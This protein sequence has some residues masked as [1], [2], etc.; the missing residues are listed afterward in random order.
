MRILLFIFCFLIPVSLFS[1]T[2]VTKG[3]T[4]IR[5]SPD[6]NSQILLTTNK[7]VT[8]NTITNVNG[9]YQINYTMFKKGWI[10]ENSLR[11]ASIK[12]CLNFNKY[13]FLLYIIVVICIVVAII[14]LFNALT[15]KCPDCKKLFAIHKTNRIP[16]GQEKITFENTKQIDQLY[17]R[18]GNRAGQAERNEQ[19]RFI[20]R[21]YND[22][23]KCKY[24][25]HQHT[26]LVSTKV[27]G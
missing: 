14:I 26:L 19:R 18:Q 24:C 21:Y 20:T 27:Q 11:N 4:F 8:F 9:W 3:E 17:D 6:A 15:T 22:I 5:I 25:K 10:Y 23:Y 1:G 12:E 13:Y 7:N 2:M 16:T